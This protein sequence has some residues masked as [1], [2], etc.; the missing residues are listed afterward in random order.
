MNDADPYINAEGVG[1]KGLTLIGGSSKN[2]L[3]ALPFFQV[4]YVTTKQ[5]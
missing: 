3:W 5:M 1:N 4:V 2:K